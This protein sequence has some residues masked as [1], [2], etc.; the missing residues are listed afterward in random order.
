MEEVHEGHGL[1]GLVN[2]IDRDVF[3][4]ENP[5]KIINIMLGRIRANAGSQIRDALD[6][7]RYLPL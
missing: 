4:N 6:E 7:V 5:A 2:S 1:G 3:L